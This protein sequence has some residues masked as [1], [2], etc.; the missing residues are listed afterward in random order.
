MIRA[1]F[2]IF[3]LAILEPAGRGALAGD[4]SQESVPTGFEVL[5]LGTYH[6]PAMFHSP[7]YTP[8]HIR[9]TL[10]KARPEVVGVE[11]HP[12]WFASGRY[13]VV[14]WEAEGVAVP[15]ARERGLS[16]YGVDWKDI[17]AWDRKEELDALRETARLEEALARS[18][19]LPLEMF[20]AF[21]RAVSPQVR[22]G[23][24]EM[25][26]VDWTFIN[27]VS[28][29]AF[30]SSQWSGKSPEDEDFAAPRDRGIAERCSEVMRSHPGKRLVVVIGAHHKPFLDILFSRMEGVRVL[31]LGRDVELPSEAEIARAWTVED[32][33]AVLGHA[34]D[35]PPRYFH[36]ELLDRERLWK[37]LEELERSGERRDAARYFRA[38]LLTAEGRTAEAEPILDELC[39]E[40]LDGSVY[41]CPL[42]EWRMRFS[43]A[44]A[45]TLEKARLLLARNEAAGAREL[46][47]ELDAS[48]ASRLD[49][50]R[51]SE[52]GQLRQIDP[53][54]DAGFERGE[55]A[56]D[57]FDGWDTYLATGH[58]RL[59]F[60]G[61]A[62]ARVEGERSLCLE[63]LEANPKDYGFHVRQE[64]TLPHSAAGGELRFGLATR[65]ENLRFARLEVLPP[66][67]SQDR[68]PLASV[69]LRLED[70][71]FARTEIAFPR[72]EHGQFA[73]YVTF[74]GPPGAR[75]WL[76]QGTPLTTQYTTVASNAPRLILAREFTRTLR[77]APP[78]PS[79]EAGLVDGGFEV[80]ALATNPMA[81]WYCSA[82]S[83]SVRTTL[84]QD[85]KV[86]GRQSLRFEILARGAAGRPALVQCASLEPATEASELEFTVALRADRPTAVALDLG[87][88]PSPVTF[89]S[90]AT[91]EVE[92]SPGT[93]T[94]CTLCTRVPQPGCLAAVFVYLPEESGTHL[95]VDDAR[96]APSSR[97]P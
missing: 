9:A 94:R 14:T 59:R 34:L 12:T 72:P 70:G 2:A 78:A 51:K 8:A 35:T 24:D 79:R 36:P 56:A 11:S 50:A 62:V 19:T 57:V 26:R 43:L 32:R 15:F 20:G 44:D 38:R 55:R 65:S 82:T 22:Q 39:A 28:G 91:D 53:V 74:D 45:V 64:V 60:S 77:D 81:G 3:A 63:V 5:V 84:D 85:V 52:P 37:I 30:G 92:L 16:V 33:I 95:W 7:A 67:W 61:D 10:E 54:H 73:L 42:R 1:H 13:H 80:G 23:Q 6:A 48:F 96:L 40:G 29:D 89:A 75:L 25:A 41:P 86:E 71:L 69:R 83:G 87:W 21:G 18:E 68:T 46:L 76:D 47:T 17:E 66:Y 90:L 97:R 88:Y 49:R 4:A 31:K 93:W 27:D 58:G